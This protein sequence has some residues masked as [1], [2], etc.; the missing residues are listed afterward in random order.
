MAYFF[1][2]KF[3]SIKLLN[4]YKHST[5]RRSINLK[6]RNLHFSELVCRDFPALVRK[7]KFMF[8]GSKVFRGDPGNAKEQEKEE[9]IFSLWLFVCIN[10]SQRRIFGPAR[11]L[12]H[13]SYLHFSAEQTCERVAK[14]EEEFPFCRKRT[15]ERNFLR[16]L[17]RARQAK[18]RCFD[19]INIFLI[20][21][22]ISLPNPT[23]YGCRLFLKAFG[24]LCHL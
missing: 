10:Y 11:C 6:Q 4:I 14:G 12:R 8:L 2:Q 7:G 20:M 1:G 16:F 19:E 15:A 21:I 24:K 22:D 23:I 9:N 3:S 18:L 5:S 13:F 17:S